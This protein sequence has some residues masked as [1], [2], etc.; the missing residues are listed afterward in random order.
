VRVVLFFM[1]G[2]GLDAFGMD[3]AGGRF[4]NSHCLFAFGGGYFG[5]GW[6]REKGDLDSLVDIFIG[7]IDE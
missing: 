3:V 6:V 5:A 4:E 2:I 1:G 7:V